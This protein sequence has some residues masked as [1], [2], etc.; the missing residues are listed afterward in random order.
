M[1]KE[2][3][4][5]LIPLIGVQ[6]SDLIHIRFV[7]ENLFPDHELHKFGTK[8]DVDEDLLDGRVI[9][10]HVGE[11]KQQDSQ[12]S[13]M[14]QDAEESEYSII[15]INADPHPQIMDCGDLL[16]DKNTIYGMLLDNMPKKILP[17]VTEHLFGLSV[18]DIKKTIALTSVYHDKLNVET[19]RQTKEMLFINQ[20]G[21]VK[22][23]TSAPFF[24]PVEGELMKWVDDN[25]AY[26]FKDVDPRLIPKGLLL[27]G[28][29]GTG[30]TEFAKFIARE[31]GLPCF[32]LDMNSMLSK[33]QGEAEQHLNKALQ[34]LDDESPCV[35]LFD[36]VEKLFAKNSENDTSQRLLSKILWWLQYKTSRVLV[37]MTCNNMD[38]IPPEL[39]R[40]G[41]LNKSVEMQGIPQK[42]WQ[43]FVK[44][45]LATYDYTGS[46]GDCLTWV[47]VQVDKQ[48]KKGGIP[49][50]VLS[51]WVIDYL[52]DDNF[53]I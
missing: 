33:W 50:A 17:E 37:V 31:W 26:M 1:L 29:A 14:Y 51:Q 9:F 7:L 34:T 40:A 21:V 13:D 47:G 44:Q 10:Y 20:V 28:E 23:D 3:V 48:Y 25:R 36:E 52:I 49:Q 30:K 4:E 8:P 15:F 39:Y 2:A 6:S 27:H 19:I 24:F 45:L 35:V 12:L 16:P 41:R 43:Q 46:V 11:V 22:I 53:G 42:Q 32:L 18:Q 5:A 38:V